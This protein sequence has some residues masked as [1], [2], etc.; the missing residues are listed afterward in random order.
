MQLNSFVKK[1]DELYEEN[2]IPVSPLSHAANQTK[3]VLLT[4]L[5]NAGCL[6]SGEEKK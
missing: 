1:I 6:K 2:T 5:E 4:C 3:K